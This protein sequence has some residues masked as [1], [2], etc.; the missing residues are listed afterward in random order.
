MVNRWW[1]ATKGAAKY[2]AA[3]AGGDIASP[4]TQALR[5][6]RCSDCQ[7]ATRRLFLGRRALWCGE[8]FVETADTCGCLLACEAE[9]QVGV[10]TINGAAL[11]PAGKLEVGSERCPRGVW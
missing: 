9:P 11:V 2:A 5:L 10:V 8:P 1:T 7:A 3:V 6:V 4:E